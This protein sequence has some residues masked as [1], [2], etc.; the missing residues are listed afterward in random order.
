MKISAIRIP[1]E[2][3]EQAQDF[4]ADVVGWKKLFGSSRDG[5][6]GFELGEAIVLL[7]PAEPGEFETGRYL[8]FSVAVSNIATFYAEAQARGLVFTG[9]PAAQ[10]WGGLMT[11]AQDPSGNTFSIVEDTGR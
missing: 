8:G 4:Y 10:T 7:E 3:L 6:I 11:H 2:D 5:Y 1:C 9:P